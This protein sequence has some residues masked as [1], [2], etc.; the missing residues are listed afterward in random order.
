KV[1]KGMGSNDTTALGKPA[2]ATVDPK[3]NE[4]YIADGY[5]NRRVIVFDATTGAYKRH[6]GAYGKK[7]DDSVKEPGCVEGA[8]ATQFNV[9]HA[10]RV[11][12]DGLVYVSDRANCRIQVFKTDGT[13]VNEVFLKMAPPGSTF[14]IDFSVDKEQRFL[15]SLD[16]WNKK[17]W[18]L[19]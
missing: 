13:Y 5:G 2:G 10:V 1:G 8:K 15:Y 7:P 14:D 6:W 12:R 9:P 4:L 17:V 18:I 16:G 3:T 11:S 19:R